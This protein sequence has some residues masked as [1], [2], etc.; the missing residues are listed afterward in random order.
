MAY[1]TFLLD[2]LAKGTIR[3]HAG[4][5]KFRPDPEGIPVN[6]FA[7]K[8]TCD[9]NGVVVVRALRNK[10]L[11]VIAL[12]TWSNS[13]KNREQL[14]SEPTTYQWHSVQESI[15]MALA[16]R[17]ALD[18]EADA[19]S[20]P[21][22]DADRRGMKTS[23]LR[24]REHVNREVRDRNDEND[25]ESRGRPPR[26]PRRVIAVV[27]VAILAGAGV[28]VVRRAKET[29]S[30]RRASTSYTTSTDHTTS[31]P[32]PAAIPST[33]T[34]AA[35]SRREDIAT[36]VARFDNLDDAFAAVK[37]ALD[38][39]HASTSAG[40][41]TLASYPLRWRDVDVASQ[42][43]LAKVEKDPAAE[44]GKRVCPE[45]T[46]ER[47]TKKKLG[48]RTH[49]AGALVTREG[50]RVTFV[51]AGATGELVKR[52]GARLCGIV[53]GTTDGATVLFGMFDL[54]ENRNPVLEKP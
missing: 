18:V 45:G 43:T 41:D 15:R 28:Y 46:I 14:D 20:E 42:T 31:S 21:L 19:I 9:S 33:P 11:R 32:P 1:V 7:W 25:R 35:P 24:V 52:E 34:R 44:M 48:G 29:T 4:T 17:A 6:A 10:R 23:D 39:E 54:P 3:W 38:P 5:L 16:E 27:G 51:A 37:P 8:I 26:F 30:S 22:T 13:L 40:L 36:R 2:L 12:A 47:I 49:F 53:T 50:D